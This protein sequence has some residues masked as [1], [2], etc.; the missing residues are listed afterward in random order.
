MAFETSTP[1]TSCVRV[2]TKT[3]PSA[4]RFPEIGTRTIAVFYLSCGTLSSFT[5]VGPWDTIPGAPWQAG[6]GGS[7]HQATLGSP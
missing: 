6:M 2:G 3:Y 1:G 7:H 5:D 4:K